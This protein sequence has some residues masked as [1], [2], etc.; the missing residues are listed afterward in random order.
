MKYVILKIEVTDGV[1]KAFPYIFCDHDTH[2][3][4]AK[5][6]THML[7]REMDRE[8]VVHSAGFCVPA[9]SSFLCTR[10]SESL[11]IKAEHTRSEEDERLLTYIDSTSGIMYD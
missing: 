1:Y 5:S 3:V 11:K 8:A 7:M 4:V 9:G 2:S 6:M 10:G